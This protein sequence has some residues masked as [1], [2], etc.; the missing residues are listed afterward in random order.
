MLIT[1]FL[2][3]EIWGELPRAWSEAWMFDLQLSQTRNI[4]FRR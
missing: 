2:G 1:N 4:S 3:T